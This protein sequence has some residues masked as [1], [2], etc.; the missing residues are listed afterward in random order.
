MGLALGM[1]LKFYRNLHLEVT[2]EK[3][4]GE[5]GGVLFAL[6]SWIA[7]SNSN[8]LP[9]QTQYLTDNRL[10]FASLSQDKIEKVIQNLD[11]NKAHGHDSI[12]IRM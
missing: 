3:L 2:Q 10:S 8:K 11:P 6:P 4:V 1:A 7:L 12:S 5:G 9:S